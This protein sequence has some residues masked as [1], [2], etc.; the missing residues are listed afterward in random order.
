[1]RYYILFNSGSEARRLEEVIAFNNEFDVF[2]K[3]KESIKS[4]FSYD[5]TTY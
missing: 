4:L 5:A 1:M 2:N 3:I